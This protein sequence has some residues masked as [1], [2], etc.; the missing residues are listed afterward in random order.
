MFDIV[1]LGECLIDFTPSGK[2]DG[3]IMLYS[4]NPGGA[5]A[6]VLA[7]ATILGSKTAFIGKVGD[8]GFGHFLKKKIEAVGIDCSNLILDSDH[9]TTLAFVTLDDRGDR[10]F[11]FY[12]DRTADVMLSSSEVDLSLLDR[13]TVFH[14]G[15]VSMTYEPARS[16]TFDVA[17]KAKE[18]GKLISFDPNFRPLLWKKTDDVLGVFKKAIA[19][20]DIL[21]VSEEEMILITGTD[22]FEEGS[23]LLES[24][25]PKLVVVTAGAKGAFI[26]RGGYHELIKTY[27]TKTVDTTGAGDA[28]WGA[29]LNVLIDKLGVKDRDVL[30]SV[31]E[32][33]LESA[34]RFANAAGSLTTEKRGAIP[35]MP[36]Y[37]S[38]K[39]CMET[40]PV[41]NLEETNEA[42]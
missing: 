12:R 8:D 3:D 30:L 23:K 24:M 20:S 22:D 7:M 18:L 25:G 31:S 1:A 19:I 29:F 27:D 26:R 35:A 41:L 9:Q 21:K 37:S 6:N 28:F 36:D 33:A 17:R 32:E 11:S 40:V 2:G 34:I 14:F 39:V 42:K 5:P 10:S 38:I 4:Q 15:S 13:C 16:T